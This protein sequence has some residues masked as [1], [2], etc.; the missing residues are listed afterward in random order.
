MRCKGRLVSFCGG[1]RRRRQRSESAAARQ[2][3]GVRT[4]C[5][6]SW[7]GLRLYY[8]TLI[9]ECILV[10]TNELRNTVFW[11]VKFGGAVM[12]F[13]IQRIVAEC[14]VPQPILYDMQYTPKSQTTLNPLKYSTN[15]KI[16][17]TYLK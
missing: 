8:G 11:N 6:V 16:H 3:R 9:P 7:G 5:N 15:P 14:P 12:L 13:Q 4:S 17:H 2:S 10:F 1:V